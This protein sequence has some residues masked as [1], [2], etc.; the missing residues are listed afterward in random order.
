MDFFLYPAKFN[1]IITPSLSYVFGSKFF[2]LNIA[3]FFVAGI[4]Y[5]PEFL[6]GMKYGALMSIPAVM[7]SPFLMSNESIS[8]RC[9]LELDPTTV[10]LTGPILEEIEYRHILQR[11]LTDII[12]S[13]FDNDNAKALSISLSS[14]FF[15]LSHLSHGHKDVILHCLNAQIGGF[16]L[17]DLMDRFGLCSSIA[18]HTTYNTIS[19][20][21]GLIFS[22]FLTIEK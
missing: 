11:G 21:S 17:G 10:I 12:S 14:T 8:V 22:K 15:G 13:F 7:L 19:I 6:T 2:P 4:K 9:C 18:A 20:L 1:S 16:I 3:A 5:K